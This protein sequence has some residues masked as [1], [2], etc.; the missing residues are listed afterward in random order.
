MLILAPFIL[1]WTILQKKVAAM[2]CFEF[3]QD[4]VSKK[5]A[6]FCK[7]NIYYSKTTGDAGSDGIPALSLVGR[8]SSLDMITSFLIV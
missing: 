6:F 3:R 2:R 7:G 4:S 1:N 8:D 5:D